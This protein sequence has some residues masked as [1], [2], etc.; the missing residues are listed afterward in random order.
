M[1]F[2]SSTF[3]HLTWH[4]FAQT[5]IRASS[6]HA[7]HGSGRRGPRAPLCALQ[8]AARHLPRAPARLDR[9]GD[10][11]D[12]A[13][14]LWRA[15]AAVRQC[16]V[17]LALARVVPLLPRPSDGRDRGGRLDGRVCGGAA[18]AGGQGRDDDDAYCEGP[19]RDA[20]RA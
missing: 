2:L 13:L 12:V 3:H 20:K 17:V 14:W 18:A 11:A 4:T 7:L 6:R 19:T 16:G 9:L 1:S 5:H 15:A 10:G 8:A